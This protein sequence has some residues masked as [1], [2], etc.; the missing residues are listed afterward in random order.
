MEN[1]VVI[2]ILSCPMLLKILMIVLYNVIMWL[3][4][5]IDADIGKE[6]AE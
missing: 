5:G 2:F 3:L 4:Y 1:V 6:E